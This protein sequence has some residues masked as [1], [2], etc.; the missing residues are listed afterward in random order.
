MFNP[1]PYTGKR[2][3]WAAGYPQQQDHCNTLLIGMQLVWPLETKVD[4][5]KIGRKEWQAGRDSGQLR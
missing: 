4:R 5:L 2:Q 3:L 1:E